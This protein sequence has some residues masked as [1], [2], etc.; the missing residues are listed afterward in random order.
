MRFRHLV[1]VWNRDGT[2]HRFAV[3]FRKQDQLGVG[4]GLSST[5]NWRI[6]AS[7]GGTNPQLSAHAARQTT[8]RFEF[9]IEAGQ[10]RPGAR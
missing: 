4:H 3:H 7:V 9:L 5:A 8:F 10:S 1:Y 2:A 6:S